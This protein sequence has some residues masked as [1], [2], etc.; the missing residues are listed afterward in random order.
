MTILNRAKSLSLSFCSVVLALGMLLYGCLTV[1]KKQPT[2]DIPAKIEAKALDE[3]EALIE[4]KETLPPAQHDMQRLWEHVRMLREQDQWEIMFNCI[5]DELK[6]HWSTEAFDATMGFIF[7]LTDGLSE[8]FPQ[9]SKSVFWI[10]E[11]GS[12][13]ELDSQARGQYFMIATR[14]EARDTALKY[15]I[16]RDSLKQFIIILEQHY[17]IEA[18]PEDPSVQEVIRLKKKADSAKT[19]LV[20]KR[21][22]FISY[23]IVDPVLAEAE[24]YIFLS[25]G[26]WWTLLKPDYEELRSSVLLMANAFNSKWLFECDEETRFHFFRVQTKLKEMCARRRWDDFIALTTLSDSWDP[27]KYRGADAWWDGKY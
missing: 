15:D 12:R 18:S 25:R 20:T 16:L 3:P 5:R 13:K 22:T 8:R 2:E 21:C 17:P 23:A 10:P 27:S 9:K 11:K 14:T 4:T 24:K 1:D 26:K 7:E 19:D 6:N